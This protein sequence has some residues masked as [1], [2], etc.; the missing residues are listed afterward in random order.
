M[1]LKE[2]KQY[3][4]RF[5]VEEESMMLIELLYKQMTN[6]SAME[7]FDHELFSLDNP[8]RR[9]IELTIKTEQASHVFKFY[10]KT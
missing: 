6:I 10:E 5:K 3:L 9:F 7:D 8:Y 4:K 1:S 2:I